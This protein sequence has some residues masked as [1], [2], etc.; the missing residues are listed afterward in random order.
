MVKHSEKEEGKETIKLLTRCSCEQ[1]TNPNPCPP[2]VLLPLIFIMQRKKPP[3]L[4]TT[5][6]Q[7]CYF[8]GINASWSFP[9]D[10]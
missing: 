1:K 5:N 2:L 3:K 8:Y 10:I 7:P 6:S 4:H 9:F